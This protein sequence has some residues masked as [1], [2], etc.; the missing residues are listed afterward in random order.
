MLTPAL[1]LFD[2]EILNFINCKYTVLLRKWFYAATV[3][4]KTISEVVI[5]ALTA[6]YK[7]AYKLTL[8]D[9][10]DQTETIEN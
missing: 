6:L 1:K 8:G 2:I 4:L 7:G 5:P 10:I 9:V 3:I